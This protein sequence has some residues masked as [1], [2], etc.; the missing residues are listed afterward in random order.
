MASGPYAKSRRSDAAQMLEA[1]ILLAIGVV[2]AVLMLVWLVDVLSFT[3]VAIVVGVL[4]GLGIV[5]GLLVLVAVNV[6]W[7]GESITRLK[8]K[9]RGGERVV[10]TARDGTALHV[11][12][13]RPVNAVPVTVVFLHTIGATLTSWASHRAL[14]DDAKVTRVFVDA[15]G[16]G[17]SSWGGLDPAVPGVRQFAEDV[18]A[19]IDAVAPTGALVLVGHGLGGMTITALDAVRPD[20]ASR[21]GGVLLC[22]STGG[23]LRKTARF[24]L[25]EFLRPLLGIVR[26]EAPGMIML[27]G[28]LPRFVWRLLGIGPYLIG[29]RVLGVARDRKAAV[30]HAAA[31]AYENG[32]R[33]LGPA[34][35]A[36]LQHDERAGLTALAGR[37]VATVEAFRD[38]MV[39]FTSQRELGAAIAGA[40]RRIAP[41][42]GHLVPLEAPE[43]VDEE[44]KGVIGEVYLAT[45][46]GRA[47]LA[48]TNATAGAAAGSNATAANATAANGTAANG[49]AA[50]RPRPRPG[51][52]QVALPPGFPQ[53]V[54]DAGTSAVE[55]LLHTGQGLLKSAAGL[56]GL[57][58]QDERH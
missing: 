49:G 55:T 10:V 12:V 18:G 1:A 11:E 57:T 16:H 58:Q 53:A 14:L 48:S 51:P 52:R 34:L 13:D 37:E 29:V 33:A 20:L 30:R 7:R 22:A 38:G 26:R 3:L 47:A 40:R 41:E 27:M 8:Q 19:V 28:L 17:Q 15:R 2:V 24:G 42:A 56:L 6:K 23:G 31:M 46:H 54:D 32:F 50:P 25:P 9:S 44:L 39:P 45:P 43:L 5:L 21:V 4:A 35:A 36:V